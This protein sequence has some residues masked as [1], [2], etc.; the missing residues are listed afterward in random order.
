MH[1]HQWNRRELTAPISGAAAWPL[2]MIARGFASRATAPAWIAL[3]LLSPIIMQPTVA[4]PLAPAEFKWQELGARVFEQ[5]CGVCHQ[6]GR[7]HV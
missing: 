7:A 3:A 4:Q 5:S 2:A 6:I 1:L